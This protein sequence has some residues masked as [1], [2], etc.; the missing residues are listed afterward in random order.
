[1]FSKIWTS[2]ALVLALALQVSARTVVAP[3]LG[4]SGTPMRNNV[5][6]PNTGSPC[7]P[8]VNIA[9]T[10]D[11]S[12]AVAANA[13][14]SFKATEININRCVFIVHYE[15]D[16]EGEGTYTRLFAL[17]HRGADGSS[18]VTA[19]TYSDTT[20]K[21]TKTVATTG[22][23][24]KTVATTVTTDSNSVSSPLRE[25]STHAILI[26]SHR[27]GPRIYRLSACFAPGRYE[28]YRWTNG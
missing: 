1:M 6:R 19:I 22:K 7:G 5:K 11:T 26:V 17:V 25:G 20:G 27:S 13:A 24:T 16:N 23:E 9:N 2:A 15:M 21:E 10:I 8:G 12:T 14:G 4:V 28:M 18:K 3:V